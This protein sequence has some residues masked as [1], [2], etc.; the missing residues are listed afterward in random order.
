MPPRCRV[1]GPL[2][3]QKFPIFPLQLRGECGE[4]VA[5]RR[6]GA[7]RAAVSCVAA[8]SRALDVTT[9]R[10]RHPARAQQHRR[11]AREFLATFA[12][13]PLAHKREIFANEVEETGSFASS[14]AG[15][16]C[17]NLVL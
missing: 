17:G 13:S 4:L 3:Q 12:S 16:D 6:R 11:R 15:I 9:V 14:D 8:I 10:T 2:S 1:S 5:G 7:R